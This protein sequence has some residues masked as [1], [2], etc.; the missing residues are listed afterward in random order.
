MSKWNYDV[1]YGQSYGLWAW[2]NNESQFYKP[3][4][5]VVANGVLSINAKY[6]QTKLPTG[7]TFE[8]TSGRINTNGKFAVWPGMTSS[9]GR[10]W[11]KIRIEA[12]LKATTPCG[13]GIW[14]A[15]WL[16]PQNL[17]YGVWAGSGEI[18]MWEMQNT[19]EW[20]NQAVHYGGPYPKYNEF[21]HVRTPRPNGKQYYG[22]DFTTITLDWEL[23]KLTFYIDGVKILSPKTKSLPYTYV[24]KALN[25]E[26][27]FYTISPDAGPN[28]PFDIPFYFIVNMAIGGKWPGK[29]NE[30]TAACMPLSYQIDYIRVMGAP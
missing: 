29:A 30:V 19:Y 18:D 2:G 11:N 5:V 14:I 9:D 24:S 10:V 27:G 7:Y 1:G 21:Q 25:E 4:N 6:E 8:Y 22:P 15:W 28:A 20:I 23:G 26:Y 3:E 17:K 16:N 13:N 12:S